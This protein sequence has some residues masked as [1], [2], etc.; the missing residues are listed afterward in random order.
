MLSPKVSVECGDPQL[1]LCELLLH[2]GE[3]D[4]EAGAHLFQPLA[5]RLHSFREVRHCNGSRY[6]ERRL[7][8]STGVP[9]RWVW[10][11]AGRSKTSKPTGW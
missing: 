11:G 4:A 3:V 6:V 5:T 8:G 9:K 2:D 10:L 7:G 1:F